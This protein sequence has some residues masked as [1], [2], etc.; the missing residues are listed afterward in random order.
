MDSDTGMSR[1]IKAVL[2]SDMKGYSSKM[3]QDEDRA[4]RLMEEHDRLVTPIVEHHHGKLIKKIGDAIMAAFATA[5]DAVNCAIEIQE[6]LASHNQGKEQADQIVIRIGIHVGEVM[7]K[8]GDLFG[9]GVN[10]AARIEPHAEP[11]GV[12]VSQTIVS[13]LQAQPQFNFPSGGD[14]RVKNIQETL[15]I[16]H[17]D[18]GTAI[19]PARPDSPKEETKG[20]GLRLGIGLAAVA[21]FF[22]G[23]LAIKAA[24]PEP[25]ATSP[26]PATAPAEPAA[27]VEQSPRE[28]LLEALKQREGS[29]R[30]GI[31]PLEPVECDATLAQTLTEHFADSLRGIPKVHIIQL[32]QS[33]PPDAASIGAWAME[34]GKAS[35]LD[36]IVIGSVGFLGSKNV[37]SLRRFSTQTGELDRRSYRLVDSTD[38]LL[39][40]VETAWLELSNEGSTRRQD[41]IARAMETLSDTLAICADT[42][43]AN[44]KGKVLVSFNIAP[45]GQV[46]SVT[47]GRN[48]IDDPKFNQC[49]MNKINTWL[50]PQS[51]E[52]VLVNYPYT[53]S[54]P[55][56]P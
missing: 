43:A 34:Q 12:A 45:S 46:D 53:F 36:Y 44:K 27:P 15:P 4:F 10:I 39:A 13:M 28:K 3:S 31:A 48:E 18:R 32:S 1:G 17:V 49:V 38:L 16:F 9:H 2:F 23:W 56:Q 6:V 47:L 19:A 21:I 52:P 29:F 55:S 30:V 51:T 22:L 33:A 25:V 7:E 24:E 5:S 8:E 14:R 50:F 41:D 26:V 11:G 20:Q 40:E 37:L 54:G 42:H 35:Y